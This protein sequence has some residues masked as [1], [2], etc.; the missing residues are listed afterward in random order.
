MPHQPVMPASA[1]IAPISPARAK[2]AGATANPAST[3]ASTISP[4]AICTWRNSGS[5]REAVTTGRPA[6][7]QASMPPS[8][9]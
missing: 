6:A 1:S 4:T 7:F 2:N 8:R 9:L 3:S 5:A